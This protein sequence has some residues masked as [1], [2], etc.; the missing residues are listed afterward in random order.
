M[1]RFSRSER[2]LARE[3]DF[4]PSLV[5]A[6]STKQDPVKNTREST[7]KKKERIFTFVHCYAQIVRML[8]G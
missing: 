6:F 8:L 1:K 7:G 4:T 5:N 2:R 3:K